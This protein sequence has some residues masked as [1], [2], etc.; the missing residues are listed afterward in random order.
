L[1][2]AARTAVVLTLAG[3]VVVLLV[4]ASLG[5]AVVMLFVGTTG[6]PDSSAALCGGGDPIATASAVL[7][8]SPGTEAPA[9]PRVDGRGTWDTEQTA[10][11]STLVAVGR[12]M[13][14]PA[15][16]WVI[17][18]A[19]GMQESGLRN[20]AGGDRDSIGVLQQRPSMGWGAPEQLRDPAHQARRFYERLRGLAGWETMRLTDAA[21]AVQ[22][23]AFPELYQQWEADAERVV[24]A[25]TGTA[26]VDLL[27]GGAPGAPCGVDVLAAAAADGTWVRPLNA[28]VGSLFRSPLRPHHNGVDFEAGRYTPIHAASNGTV[29]T[30]LCNAGTGD[31]DRD[32]SES[33]TGCG[34]YVEVLHAG[35]VVT[36]YCHMVTRPLV[37]VGDPVR[38]GQVIGFVGSSGNSSGPHLHFEVHTGSPATAA[39]AVDPAAFMARQ[40]VPLS[41][42]PA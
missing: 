42:P 16:G 9:V 5:T 31:C 24:A 7:A 30:V 26:S 20:L 40:G 19:T 41:L 39:N 22:R 17:A 12:D 21:Q 10:I 38:A 36:R 25:V 6:S 37:A 23:S 2:R 8:Q 4:C 11:A 15:R 27:G 18:V 13:E 32:G 14:I 33:V 1:K 34:W 3:A 29:V 28:R 35:D